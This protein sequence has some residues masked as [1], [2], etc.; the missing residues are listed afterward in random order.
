MLYSIPLVNTCKISN[1]FLS[2]DIINEC[3]ANSKYQESIQV[4][5]T[6]DKGHHMG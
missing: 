6:S 4:S 1:K 3:T 2:N 5:I